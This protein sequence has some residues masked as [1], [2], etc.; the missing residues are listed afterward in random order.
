SGRPHPARAAGAGYLLGWP[1]GG[2]GQG[3]SGRATA[4]IPALA[5]GRRRTTRSR[6]GALNLPTLRRN[7]RCM[8]RL[9]HQISLAVVAVLAAPMLAH[10][11]SADLVLCDRLAADPSDPDKPAE[12]KGVAEVAAAD[13]ATSIKYCAVAGKSQRRAM[14]Q[15]GRA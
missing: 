9:L 10:T 12:V 13:I 15:L 3:G 2:N 7:L 6:A 5:R 4:A 11:Q 14:Y 1:H 8:R